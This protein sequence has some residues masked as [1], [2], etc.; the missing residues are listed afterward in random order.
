MK[1]IQISLLLIFQ[2]LFFAQA[3]NDRFILAWYD[4]FRINESIDTIARH[5]KNMQTHYFNCAIEEYRLICLTIPLDSSHFQYAYKNP[6]KAFLDSAY[7]YI[8]YYA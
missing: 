7:K 1:K 6:S 5:Y 4:Y 2:F 8:A 3:Q